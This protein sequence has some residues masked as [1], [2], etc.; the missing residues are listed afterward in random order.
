MDAIEQLKADV[1]EGRIDAHRLIDLLVAQQRRLEAALQRIAELERKLGGPGASTPAK[2]D[3]PFSVRSEEKRQ[4]DQKQDG[5][6]SLSRNARRGRLTNADKLKLAERTE[7]CYPEGVPQDECWLSHTRPVW[8]LEQGRAV[9]VAY[10]IHRASGDR[11]GQIPGALGRAEFGMEIVVQVAYLVYVMGMSFG[12]VS[13]ALGFL[14]NLPLSKTQVDALLHRLSRQW[15]HE[16]EVLCALLAHSL[17]VHADETSWSINSVWAFL[18]EKARVLFFGVHKD[19]DTLAKILDPASFAGLV[20]SDDAAVYANFTQSQ[21]C[22]AHLLR[23]AIKL[24]LQEP[25][26]QEYRQFADGLLDVYRRA[27]K[28]QRDG[29]LSDAG[30]KRK[31]GEL[32]DAILA[33]CLDMWCLELPPLQES[34]ENDYRLL[35]NELM[36]LM[37]DRHLFAFVTTKAAESPNGE[38]VEAPGTNNEAE[39][40]LRTSAQARDTGRTNKTLHGARRRTIIVSVI[41]SLRLYLSEFSLKDVIAEIERWRQAGQSCF[42]KLLNRMNL[43]LPSERIL[44]QILPAP[45]S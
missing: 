40:S 43:T 23:K 15:R 45:D 26:N 16:F 24:T 39:R 34:A 35:C 21:K 18:S 14:Q 27:C 32:D 31:V 7:D 6:S 20:V 44:D 29:R 19:G 5:K 12:Q 22:W 4:R 3:Q 17:I 2:I 33:L 36:K 25:D 13:A 28:A 10:R 37:L 1:R 30:R 8:R 38:I 9:L 41:D 42:E 11:Y